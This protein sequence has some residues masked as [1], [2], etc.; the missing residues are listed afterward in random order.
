M[1]EVWTAPGEDPA[2]FSEGVLVSAG[3]A[4]VER[5]RQSLLSPDAPHARLFEGWASVAKVWEEAAL[6]LPP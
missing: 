2:V 5:I 6:L 1:E 4:K 3:E